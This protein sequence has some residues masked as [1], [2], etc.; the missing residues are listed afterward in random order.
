VVERISDETVRRTLKNKLKPWQN[1]QWC[2]PQVDAIFVWRMEDVLDLCAEPYK[3][4]QPVL[5]L[6]SFRVNWWVMIS[7]R[8][9]AIGQSTRFPARMAAW[10]YAPA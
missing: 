3:P 1:D 4:C 6:T 9:R 8:C 5:G 7:K 10:W 2:I